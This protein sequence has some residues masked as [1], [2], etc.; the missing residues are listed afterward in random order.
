[1]NHTPPEKFYL[2]RRLRPDGEPPAGGASA[3]DPTADDALAYDPRDLTTHAVCLGMTGSGKTGLG[4]ALIEEAA[5]NGIPALVVDP[6]GDMANLLLAFPPLSAAAFRPWVDPGSVPDG[7]SLDEHVERT[8]RSWREGLAGWGIDGGRIARLKRTTE[9]AL[10]TPGSDAGRQVSILQSLAAPEGGWQRDTEVLRETISN[11]V[12]ALLTLIDVKS[13]P[14]TGREHNLLSTIVEHAWRAGQDIDLTELIARVQRPPFERLG[15]L[16]LDVFYPEKE[17]LALALAL[18]GLL[19]SPRF[20]AWLQGHPLRVASL[21]R[22]PDGRPQVSIFYL[23]HLSD[24]ERQFFVTLLLDQV[25]AWLRVQEGAQHLRAILYIDELYGMMPPHPANPPTK[26]PLLALLKQ[27]RSQGLGLVL[28]SQN[29]VDL[30][31]KGLSNAGTW[32]VGKL[33]TANDRQRA[34][35]GLREAAPG[36][37]APPDAAGPFGDQTLDEVIANLKPRTFLLHNVHEDGPV[38]FQTRHTMS[39]LRG[40]LTRRQIRQWMDIYAPRQTVAVKPPPATGQGLSGD[41]L[42]ARAGALPSG[43]DRQVDRPPAR[44]GLAREESPGLVRPE[45][46][47]SDPL[48]SEPAPSLPWDSFG[49]VLPTLPAGIDQHFM[50]VHVPLEWAIRD[51]ESEG[52]SIVYLARQLVYRPALLARATARIDNNTYNVLREV[53]VSRALPVLESDVFIDWRDESIPVDPRDLEDRPAQGARFAPVPAALSNERRLRSLARDFAE[54]VYRETALSLIQHTALKLTSRPD[55]LASEFRLRCYQLIEQE[56]DQELRQL[57]RR[58]EEKAARLEARIR[59]EERELEQDEREYEGRKREELISAGESVL[60]LLRRRRHSRML[61]IAS[62]RRRL[63]RQAKGEIEESIE[64]INDFDAQIQDLLDE[65]E[66]EKAEIQA[67]WAER[68]DDMRTIQIR[69]RKSD[70]FVE[71]WDVVWL[72]YWEIL[73]QEEGG[74]EHLALPAM[75]TERGERR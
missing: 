49:P 59:R 7:A 31:Y 75:H 13:D 43:A 28:A 45:P 27:A 63:T 71:A 8:A 67:R 53:S 12:S 15:V 52:R 62:R 66:R 46:E 3:I 23:A 57:E 38:L 2:G 6:K 55:E 11:T 21:L 42:P 69:P 36:T 14:V 24:V 61:S 17:R 19:A 48:R 5:L 60:N 68:T 35:E 64:A 1:V 34:L 20:A 26:A 33:Q 10:Y 70:I 37:A 25:R 72:P 40:P 65:S 44:Q 16:A 18:N 56:R 58:T 73:Y 4:V 9:V 74:I 22:A 41:E 51:A 47:R 54:Y 39:Y 30:D 50:P 32:F 29:P